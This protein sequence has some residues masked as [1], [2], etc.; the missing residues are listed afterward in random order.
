MWV[1]KS[2][3]SV[4][5]KIDQVALNLLSTATST[6]TNG[7]VCTH[8]APAWGGCPVN[9]RIY[10]QYQL[11][12]GN[13][14]AAEMALEEVVKLNPRDSDAYAH[15][16]MVKLRQGFHEDARRC[17][18]R[19]LQVGAGNAYVHFVQS[20]V[21]LADMKMIALPMLGISPEDGS[22]V[23]KAIGDVTE[24][25]RLDSTEP[26]YHLRNAELQGL[27]GK[28]SLA[29]AS[30]D[31]ALQFDPSSVLAGIARAEALNHLGRR[32]AAREMLFQTLAI[33][34]EASDAHSGLGWALLEAGE[35]VRARE[36]FEEALRLNP[37]S[38]W[39]QHGLLECGKRAFGL[40]RVLA[41]A[42]SWLV[43]RNQLAR[44][45]W[46]GVP[47]AALIVLLAWL[48]DL[49]NR[50]PELGWIPASIFWLFMVLVLFALFADALFG[51]LARTEKAGQ[52]T[53]AA[54]DRRLRLMQ[55]GA[56]M[57][58]IA[59]ALF[60]VAARKFGREW[61]W[62]TLG[63]VPGFYSLWVVAK[64]RQRT[65]RR[66]GWIYSVA[67]LL[68]GVPVALWLE[69]RI[70]RMPNWGLLTA[71]LVPILP[72]AILQEILSGRQRL[73]DHESAKARLR[74]PADSEATAKPS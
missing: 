63:L 2:D 13:L 19:A 44:I 59:G 27:L 54:E 68:A 38:A 4:Q 71:L 8:G 39:G 41:R 70:Q 66:L 42:R 51:W 67:I 7:E 61:L 5:L 58:G 3:G 15:L 17:V 64:I 12:R 37:N 30:V 40:Y 1:P 16:A 23:R 73:L 49:A 33:N 72:V 10:I 6:F 62:G 20:H 65:P 18:N 74:E 46:V 28:W 34:P 29:L 22:A 57:F 21:R 25:I 55:V 56:A 24:A 43:S 31:A 11:A 32:N 48:S 69:A 36:F 14:L 50:Q 60:A 9:S 52:S 47:F 35:R 26:M 53:F 45:L